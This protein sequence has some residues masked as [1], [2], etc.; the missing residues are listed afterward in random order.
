MNNFLITVTHPKALYTKSVTASK[1]QNIVNGG[2]KQKESDGELVVRVL[3]LGKLCC[4]NFENNK[5]C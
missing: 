4:N 2:G 5:Q 1:G 3:G